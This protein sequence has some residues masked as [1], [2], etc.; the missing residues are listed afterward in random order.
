MLNWPST[1]KRTIMQSIRITWLISRQERHPRHIQQVGTSPSPA[2]LYFWRYLDSY[3]SF[4]SDLGKRPRFTRAASG[5]AP[6][7]ELS[8]NAFS[9][10]VPDLRR[11]SMVS[12]SAYSTR[13]SPTDETGERSVLRGVTSRDNSFM[14]YTSPANHGFEVYAVKSNSSSVALSN[15]PHYEPRSHFVE[16]PLQRDNAGPSRS[17]SDGFATNRRPHSPSTY[18]Q[19]LDRPPKLAPITAP[20]GYLAPQPAS[21]MQALHSQAMTPAE[22]LPGLQTLIPPLPA[23]VTLSRG[24]TGTT[25]S[26]LAAYRTTTSSPSECVDLTRQGSALAVLLQASELARDNERTPSRS[27]APPY[28]HA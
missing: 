27:S 18:V 13:S 16:S 15:S 20:S 28:N 7:V 9:A 25:T 6:D 4:L 17:E 3:G 1:R 19:R 12:T 26:S 8:D 24:Q 23:P 5:H 2:R 22:P 21:S 10:S 14:A 11:K